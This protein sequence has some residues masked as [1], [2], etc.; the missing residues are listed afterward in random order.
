VV[1]AALALLLALLA[2]AFWL[3]RAGAPPPPPAVGEGVFEEVELLLFPKA[4]PEARWRFSAREVRYHPK[5]RV[6]RV[7]GLSEGARY[8]GD[9]LDLKLRAEAIEIDRYDNLKTPRAVVE[10]PKECW[11]LYLEGE[12][13]APVRIDQ[14]RGF[15]AP[16]FRLQGPGVRVEGL[17]FR[18]D[19]GLEEAS[20]RSGREEWQTGGENACKSE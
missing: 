14:A 2:A 15:F 4:D 16:R 3:T 1:R 18:A 12:G 10:I 6:A 7:E 11:K 19:F 20:W 13:S 5:T 17:G 9:A 8:V